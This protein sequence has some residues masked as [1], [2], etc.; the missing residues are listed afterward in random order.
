MI[1]E[2]LGR[3]VAGTYPESADFSAAAESLGR[4]GK[5]LARRFHSGMMHIVHTSK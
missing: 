5:F 4:N 3:D 1:E 2:L